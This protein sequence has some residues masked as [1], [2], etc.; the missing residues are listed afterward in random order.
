M[1]GNRSTNIWSREHA[2]IVVLADELRLPF[3]QL[4]SL[5]E[6][7][8]IDINYL[9]TADTIMSEAMQLIDDLLLSKNVASGQME[10]QL[11]PVGL[12]ALTDDV[13]S[14]LYDLGKI[15]GCEIITKITH[16]SSPVMAHRASIGIALK[17]IGDMFI[18]SARSMNL[19]HIEMVGHMSG[20]GATIGFFAEG[21]NVTQK[22]LD[23]ARELIANA[24]QPLHG[25]LRGSGIQLLVADTLLRPYAEGIFV[26]KLHGSR[27]LVTRLMPSRQLELVVG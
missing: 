5:L 8:N 1:A 11:E 17:Q 27:G 6:L 14:Q 25:F 23:E 13:A 24:R 10:L 15:Y 9:E 16:R 20:G 21:L 2:D 4:K 22:S 19:N 12:G 18:R 26:Q 7:L 3:L